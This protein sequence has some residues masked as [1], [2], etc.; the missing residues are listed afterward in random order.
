MRQGIVSMVGDQQWQKGVQ[1]HERAS[2]ACY[3]YN[4]K[5]GCE[6]KDRWCDEDE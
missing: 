6:I 5:D 2:K 4:D 3:P 1:K